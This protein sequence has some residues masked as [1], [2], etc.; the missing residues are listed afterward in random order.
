[1]GSHFQDDADD[2]EQGS[3]L[4]LKTLVV[5]GLCR[6]RLW[7]GLLALTGLVVGLL[8]AAS[9]P[10][11]YVSVGRLRLNV[12]KRE[13]M[14]AETVAGLED[15]RRY[16]PAMADELLLLDDPEIYRRAAQRIG[17]E[18]VLLPADPA[19]FDDE[20]TAAPVRYLHRLQSALMR[21]GR[22]ESPCI[23]GPTETCVAAAADLLKGRTE[24]VNEPGSNIIAVHHSSSTPERAQEFATVLL[25][26]FVERHREVYSTQEYYEESR[27][28]LLGAYDEFEASEDAYAEH[29]KICG[30]LDLETQKG[31]IL[32]DLS[33]IDGELH[34]RQALRDQFRAQVQALKTEAERMPREIERITPPVMGMN[35]EYQLYQSQRFELTLKRL[36]LENDNSLSIPERKASI[37]SVEQQVRAIDELLK[38]T[39]L[40]VEQ[41]PEQI[42]KSANPEYFNLMLRIADLDAQEHGLGQAVQRYESYFQRKTEDLE[43]ARKC[44]RVHSVLEMTIG[45]RRRTYDNI[46]SKAAELETLAALDVEGESNLKLFQ[47]ALRPLGKEGPKRAKILLIGL[48]A[49][50]AV[51]A[52]VAILR[53]LFDSRLRYPEALERDL[54]LAVWGVVPEA[55]TLRRLPRAGA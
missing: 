4:D 50:L 48:A 39:P 12:G 14:T 49:G 43:R 9:K 15:A 52:A 45:D 24:L 20:H 23:A 8:V 7:V 19:E 32:E 17:L 10:N 40:L 36:Q 46:A 41:V 13:A 55:R 30:F 33:E 26:C 22:P 18:K 34:M 1:M 42:Q 31:G 27:E 44:D 6:S 16:F 29:V 3:A 2:P 47:P 35:Q 28:K 25:K 53:Q 37:E 51:G 21:Y 38:T 54:G 5:Y 11:E